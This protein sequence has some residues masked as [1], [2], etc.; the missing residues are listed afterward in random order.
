MLKKIIQ[1]FPLIL[2]WVVL[3]HNFFMFFF[4][5]N[6]LYI[7]FIFFLTSKVVL[8]EEN[9]AQNTQ[10]QQKTLLEQATTNFNGV[11]YIDF[12]KLIQL[13]KQN[14]TDE[15][16]SRNYFDKYYLDEYY[17]TKNHNFFIFGNVGLG[18]SDLI[19]KHNNN[20]DTHSL[21]LNVSAGLGMMIEKSKLL[22]PFLRF[23]WTAAP[24]LYDYREKDPKRSNDFGVTFLYDFE[25]GNKFR[26]K[27]YT[28]KV[29]ELCAPYSGRHR[30]LDR[31]PAIEV[32]SANIFIILGMYKYVPDGENSTQ[33]PITQQGFATGLGVSYTWGTMDFGLEFSLKYKCLMHYKGDYMP[34]TEKIN[35]ML[36][37]GISF[38]GGAPFV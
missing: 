22:N 31:K 27:S 5:K 18:L 9:I 28:S 25:I 33:I 1:Y 20:K 15:M 19:M 4:K 12:D 10:L 14:Q 3:C 30:C 32:P 21:L 16:L 11:S 17:E 2:V 37:F 13:K 7:I 23:I 36:T 34:N 35:H 26:F 38:A 8:S 29:I 24:D 6:I